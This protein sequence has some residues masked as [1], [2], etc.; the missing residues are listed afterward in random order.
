MNEAA[1]DPLESS[2]AWTPLMLAALK[3]KVSQKYVEVMML[4]IENGADTEVADAKGNTIVH[5]LASL[6]Q[7]ALL[8]QVLHK[9]PSLDILGPGFGYLTPLHY[10]AEAGHFST[11]E[12]LLQLGAD[13]RGVDASGWT[14]MHWACRQGDKRIIGLL[15]SSGGSIEDRDFRSLTPLD[16]ACLFG[17]TAL[18][19]LLEAQMSPK[20][21]QDVPFN[22]ALPPTQSDSK[23]EDRMNRKSS[24]DLHAGAVQRSNSA[25]DF[26]AWRRRSEC[27]FGWD[28]RTFTRCCLAAFVVT[29]SVFD[30]AS[31]VSMTLF[32]AAAAGKFE[33]AEPLLVAAGVLACLS[34]FLPSIALGLCCSCHLRNTGIWAAWK[35]ATLFHV[36]VNSK[37]EEGHSTLFPRRLVLGELLVV[38][39]FKLLSCCILPSTQCTAIKIVIAGCILPPAAVACCLV[40][41]IQ[42]VMVAVVASLSVVGLW[43]CGFL[44]VTALK[45]LLV[46]PRGLLPYLDCLT[47]A[48]A[49]RFNLAEVQNQGINHTGEPGPQQL[50]N[51]G[52]GQIKPA[53]GHVCQSSKGGGRV[54][55]SNS[56]SIPKY[57][58][59]LR[60]ISQGEEEH[61]HVDVCV[62]RDTG[63]SACITSLGD[64]AVEFRRSSA[65]NWARCNLCTKRYAR[66]TRATLWGRVH[67]KLHPCP[68]LQ[69]A[70]QLHRQHLKS[71]LDKPF[72]AA[73]GERRFSRLTPTASVSS[74]LSGTVGEPGMS[75]PRETSAKANWRFHGSSGGLLADSLRAPVGVQDLRPTLTH[76][77]KQK[78][79]S[80]GLAEGCIPSP[81]ASSNC[82]A[83][84][85]PC[86]NTGQSPWIS[87]VLEFVYKG[88]AQEAT[89][90]SKV[91]VDGYP[92]DRAYEDSVAKDTT[93]SKCSDA[94][95]LRTKSLASGLAAANP[96]RWLRSEA[97][98]QG[99]PASLLAIPVSASL[100]SHTAGESHSSLARAK[101]HKKEDLKSKFESRRTEVLPPGGFRA[102][103]GWKGFK[104]FFT[105][106]SERRETSVD[107][108]KEECRQV[109]VT[110]GPPIVRI[111]KRGNKRP[112]PCQLDDKQYSDMIVRRE[113][114]IFNWYERL[115][116]FRYTEISAFRRVEAS[117][118][119]ETSFETKSVSLG[120]GPEDVVPPTSPRSSVN[121]G[122][123]GIQWASLHTLFP[124]TESTEQLV[125]VTETLDGCTP[126]HQEP[127]ACMHTEDLFDLP[128]ND[129]LTSDARPY[130]FCK[131]RH[132]QQRRLD[133][134]RVVAG[135]KSADCPAPTH[136]NKAP[137]SGVAGD[138][139]STRGDSGL[140]QLASPDMH[141]RFRDMV[142]LPHLRETFFSFWCREFEKLLLYQD[143]HFGDNSLW[144]TNALEKESISAFSQGNVSF[145]ADEVPCT[146]P[147]ASYIREEADVFSKHFNDRS[148]DVLWLVC[149]P[150]CERQAGRSF[151]SPRTFAAT[152]CTLRVLALWC[153]A[154][155]LLV[156]SVHA[157]ILF[158]QAARIFFP[159]N[160]RKHA[161]QL[162]VEA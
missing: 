151:N 58:Q 30:Y 138:G 104:L 24:P 14:P 158:S 43:A 156:S 10:A 59:D 60:T 157:L 124:H 13:P 73:H 29:I 149:Q 148:K 9:V 88:E 67:R 106:G 92:H 42:I 37:E 34:I 117:Q 68:S 86:R 80:S 100:N 133:P 49:V 136:W 130:L 120:G 78:Y 96:N 2:N 134:S 128:P 89:A 65:S 82:K 93:F 47:Y 119:N 26:N 142:E 154:L 84:L 55:R 110:P 90:I 98:K 32:L 3:S 40:L 162:M 69:G 155:A 115:V 139:S 150:T 51:R 79:W 64:P 125:D 50:P 101:V 28:G 11:V 21:R 109:Q 46:S 4:L 87:S 122:E 66:Y 97:K 52:G 33:G 159:L 56:S 152:V 31:R 118:L 123:A 99:A 135:F 103:T 127:L 53:R 161:T 116:T 85:H 77:E 126:L 6:G 153:L 16:V 160:G 15:L 76:E 19:K 121:Q 146:T 8:K 108:N 39:Y 145:R 111:F 129:S 17:H 71:R 20:S 83:A 141:Y 113:R 36:T 147:P 107:I 38:K 44:G 27:R 105:G 112:Q 35:A 7:T 63:D 91:G 72:L 143:Q 74:R 25:Y 23:T 114:C 61:G 48:S 1:V 131:P 45:V 102:R 75:T 132:D 5:I 95:S 22:T 54:D 70:I 62:P 12:F 137:E 140:D 41:L 81:C 57:G 94:S 144:V 18:A